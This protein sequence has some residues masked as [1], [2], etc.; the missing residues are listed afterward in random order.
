VDD[1]KPFNPENSNNPQ[2]IGPAQ[3]VS[4]PT[5]LGPNYSP[6]GAEP[7]QKK[8]WSRTVVGVVVF[9]LIYALF[10]LGTKFLLSDRGDAPVADQLKTLTSSEE[11][12]EFVSS[13][14]GFK[15]NFPGFP[16]TE[17]E[18]IEV[19]GVMLPY[20]VYL[21]ENDNGNKA[22]A[23]AAVNYPQE[24][25]EITE[26]NS[27][28]VLESALNGSAQAVKGR[29]VSTELT[30]HLNYPALQGYIKISQ[31]GREYDYYAFLLLKGNDLFMIYTIGTSKSDFESFQKSFTLL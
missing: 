27:N 15:I 29:I 10:N 22:Y 12:K 4:A 17:K 26:E 19:E 31:D 7:P 13:Q 14:H 5:T 20:T 25:F 11:A 16:S 18:E 6:P 23:V 30:K 24:S 1:N 9:L 3:S 8:K 2:N 21:R 28:S